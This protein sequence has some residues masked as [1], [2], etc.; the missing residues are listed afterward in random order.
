MS[1][2][3]IAGYPLTFEQVS[4]RNRF[5]IWR[6]SLWLLT[7]SSANTLRTFKSTVLSALALTNWCDKWHG[8]MWWFTPLAPNLCLQQCLCKCKGKIFQLINFHDCPSVQP[9]KIK[10]LKTQGA[11]CQH[12]KLRGTAWHWSRW[13][14]ET[15]FAY[16]ENPCGV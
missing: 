15:A 3:K 13:A 2:H 4:S 9:W 8:Q 7:V 1:T 14:L 12:T 6:K 16:E 10:K 5:R 11:P